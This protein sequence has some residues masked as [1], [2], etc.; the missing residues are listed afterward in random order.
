MKSYQI[1]KCKNI[2]NINNK[3]T[4]EFQ[5]VFNL[6]LQQDFKS[7]LLILGIGAAKVPN[8]QGSQRPQA[9]HLW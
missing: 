3:N 2:N 6:I 9:A 1:L 8:I 7:I 4:F 5:K